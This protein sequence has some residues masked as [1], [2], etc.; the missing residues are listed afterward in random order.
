MVDINNFR[1]SP[2]GKYLEI[3]VEVPDGPHYNGVNITTIRIKQVLQPH[4]LPVNNHDS[5]QFDVNIIGDFDS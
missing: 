2:D 4:D 3:W 1:V 5:A